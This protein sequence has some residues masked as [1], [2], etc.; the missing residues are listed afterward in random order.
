MSRRIF[1]ILTLT[2]ALQLSALRTVDGH[3]TFSS[4]ID[5]NASYKVLR[6]YGQIANITIYQWMADVFIRDCRR[7]KRHA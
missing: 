3:G 6:E 7:P 1:A 5:P 4:V 2:T